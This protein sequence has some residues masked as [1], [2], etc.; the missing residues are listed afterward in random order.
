MSNLG[1]YQTMTY[2]A[3]QCGGPVTMFVL[4]GLGCG[5]IGYSLCSFVNYIRNDKKIIV[6]KSDSEA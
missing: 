6:I 1:S 2:M 5:A 3:K 4:F